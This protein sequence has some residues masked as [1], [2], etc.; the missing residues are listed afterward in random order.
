MSR[1]TSIGARRGWRLVAAAMLAGLVASPAAGQEPGGDPV[2][3]AAVQVTANPVPVRAHSNPQIARHPKTGELVVV[4]SDVRGNRGCAVHISADNGRTWAPG[5]N[6]MV[7]PFTDC[8]F[9]GEYGA[10]AT[11]AFSPEGDLHVAFVASEFLARA[12]NDVPRHVYLARS[13]D[14]GRTFDTTRVFEAPEGNPD[15]GLNKGPMLAVDPN[16]SQRVYVGWRQGI[17]AAN[18]RE[19]QKSNVAASS[20]GGRTFGPP[21]DLSDERGG[22]YPALAVG[23]DGTVHAVFWTRTFPPGPNN[24]PGPARPIQY[25]RS[26]DQG[27]TFSKGVEIDPGNRSVP[28][29]P[30]LAADPRSDALYM[31]W[32]SNAEVENQA[33]DFQGYHDVFLRSS[34]DG[35]RTWGGRVTVNDDRTNANQFEPGISIAPNGRLDIAWYDFRNNPAPPTPTT[36]QGSEF[37]M[38]DVYYASSSDKG[39]TVGPNVRVTDRSMDRSLGLWKFDSKFNVGITSV[40]DAVYLAWQD[41]RNAI[42]ETDADDVYSASVVLSGRTTESAQEG[43]GVPGW[44]LVAAGAT[45]GAGT[46]MLLVGRIR[47]AGG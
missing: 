37:G 2:V 28:R 15:R 4:E 12:R 14:G 23:D 7:E 6:P 33:A 30:V 40:N 20:D 44:L 38:S 19:K 16:D 47:G 41:P 43:R 27:R 1:I 24:A 42:R 26:T 39:R 25:A 46:T 45:V 8:G 13:S 34:V 10:Y 9:Y 22:D 35:G 21:V 11:L 3:T 36:G 17:F 31:V 32:Y 5:G 18:A 29:P